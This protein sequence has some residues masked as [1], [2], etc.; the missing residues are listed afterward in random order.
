MKLFKKK[1]KFPKENV[2]RSMDEINKEYARV[3]GEAGQNQYLV[4]VYSGQLEENNKQ[5]LAL[6]QEGA[7]R[8]ELDRLAGNA[9]KSNLEPSAQKEA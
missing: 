9:I 4:F 3:L 2:P 1:E 5:L 7:K 6:N 8:Q